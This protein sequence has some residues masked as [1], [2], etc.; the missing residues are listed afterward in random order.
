MA[1]G[2]AL[3]L[4]GCGGGGAG[5]DAG[6]DLGGRDQRA[7]AKQPDAAGDEVIDAA[8][9][10]EALDG[11]QDTGEA[12][13]DAPD[14]PGAA[15]RD[16][17]AASGADTDVV[18]GADGDA[19]ATDAAAT[20]VGSGDVATDGASDVVA[21]SAPRTLSLVLFNA[22]WKATQRVQ[23]MAVDAQSRIFLE[24]QTNVYLV[25]GK[26]VST[27]LT[28]AETT[29]GTTVQAAMIKDLDLDSNGLLYVLVWGGS[30]YVPTST[31]VV[32]SSAAHVADPWLDVTASSNFALRMSVSAPGRVGIV[33][34]DGLKM[35][36]AAG[37]SLVYGHQALEGGGG[38]AAEDFRI[39]SSGVFLY[40]PG[41]NVAPL[42]RGNV[43]GSGVAV[44]YQGAVFKAPQSPY[45]PNFTCAARDPAGGFYV[46]VGS[47]DFE[48]PNL[49]HIAE[50]ASGTRGLELID[51]VPTFSFAAK[52]QSETFA[53][54]YCSLA[55]GPD[56]TVY[57][58]TYSQIWKV[59]P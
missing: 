7:E 51:T 26:T 5:R 15:F 9:P 27:Y 40:E 1:M 18:G 44:L 34:R 55:V 46:I 53:F 45:I 13:A 43:D 12:D 41:C 49:Y 39:A 32:R 22:P 48:P 24:D 19:A 38:C 8:P 21:V 31:L 42:L 57:Y 30:I 14:G 47:V 33:D 36:S 37:S 23:G 25:E 54:D 16:A 3:V 20:D 35:A 11:P 17:D 50:D 6:R 29:A 28:L 59:S 4:A 58:Q 52:T 2:L 10:V 56:G